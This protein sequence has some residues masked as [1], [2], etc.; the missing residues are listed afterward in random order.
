MHASCGI[1]SHLIIPALL[2]EDW[3]KPEQYERD[4]PDRD[5]YKAKD[6]QCPLRSYRGEEL[7]DDEGQGAGEEK[8]SRSCCSKS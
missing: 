6:V 4:G 2:P 7:E 8:T 3:S 5:R 1:G